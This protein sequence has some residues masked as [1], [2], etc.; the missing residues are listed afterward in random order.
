M[1]YSRLPGTG[2]SSGRS[3][4]HSLRR[5][6][7]VIWGMSFLPEEENAMLKSIILIGVALALSV[8]AC[9]L[10][11]VSI[12]RGV[13]AIRTAL[14]CTRPNRQLPGRAKG[15]RGRLGA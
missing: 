8:A 3:L 7:A 10:S 6:K 5:A 13:G 2:P 15:E 1:S 4:V 14:H 9:I 12:R 11:P